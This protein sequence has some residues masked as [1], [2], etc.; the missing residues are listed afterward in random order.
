M[1]GTSFGYVEKGTH[2]R[3]EAKELKEEVSSYLGI[4]R[5]DGQGSLLNM[6]S[7]HFQMSTYKKALTT[8]FSEPPVDNV[9]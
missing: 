6:A 5:I 7:N 2:L 8:V 4:S 9:Y 1:S 3:V